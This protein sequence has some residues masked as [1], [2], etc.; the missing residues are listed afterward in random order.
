MTGRTAGGRRPVAGQVSEHWE[1]ERE[2]GWCPRVVQAR[3][4]SE[5]YTRLNWSRIDRGQ[6]QALRT[7]FQHWDSRTWWQ[8]N[9][10]AFVLK[11]TVGRYFR[12]NR[13]DG[14]CIVDADWDVL[15]ILDACRFDLFSD[16]I[17][18]PGDLR[19]VHSLGSSTEEFLRA[20]FD[21]ETLHDTVYVT[22]NPQERMHLPENVFHETVRVWE[23]DWDEEVQTVRPDAMSDAVIQAG[24]D[25]PDKRIIGHFMQPHFPFLGE[26]GRELRADGLRLLKES[27]EEQGGDELPVDVWLSLHRRDVDEHEVWEAY[28]ENLSLTWPHVERVI[29][30]VRGKCVVTSDHGNLVNE[31]L[32]PFPIR[33][34][35]HPAGLHVP[36][37]IDVPWL[38]IEG[39]ERRERI[40]E[41]PRR[42]RPESSD[43]VQEKLRHLGYAE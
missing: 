15:L 11:E 13:P 20:N 30:N 27:A 22:A 16:V 19:R 37:L 4:D 35:G 3:S 8:T 2:R 18:I 24:H 40:A 28:S 14:I 32:S 25:H 31:R 36:Q 12:H 23:T 7:L 39:E 21:G 5:R 38:E 34:S 17:D 43:D 33:E 1:H 26:R 29:E 6:V 10:R 42:T 9:V 41:P